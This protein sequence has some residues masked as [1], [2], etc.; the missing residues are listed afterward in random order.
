MKYIYPIDFDADFSVDGGA[1]TNSYRL[2]DGAIDL[3]AT[4]ISNADRVQFDFDSVLTPDSVAIYVTSGTG[5]AEIL[6]SPSNQVIAPTGISA[7]W[8]IITIA[9][10]A[11][12]D[13]YVE[14]A[15]VSSLLVAEIFFAYELDFPWRYDL[16]ATEQAQFGVDLVTGMG[17]G[18]FTNKRHD[19]KTLRNWNWRSF[20]E[21]NKT[22]YKAMVTAIGGIYAKILWYDGSSYHWVRLQNTPI[23][24]EQ[25]FGSYGLGQGTRS[26][27]Q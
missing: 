24:T 22:S 20:S 15:S 23:Y 21:A 8:N 18:E 12:V 10:S 9:T 2:H 25:T 1:I 13:W 3:N 19:E 27:L 11:S 4:D 17:G 5:T 16:G 26:Q 6:N 14:F 7:G